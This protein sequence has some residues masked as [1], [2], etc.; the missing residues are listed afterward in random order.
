MINAT[1][2]MPTMEHSAS[3]PILM[4]EVINE[5]RERGEREGGERWRWRD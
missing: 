4:R 5:R 1:N 3:P 2:L